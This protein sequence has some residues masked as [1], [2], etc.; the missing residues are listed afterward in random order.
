MMDGKMAVLEKIIAMAREKMGE[1]MKNRYSPKQ[2]MAGPSSV[3]LSVESED[4]L[5]ELG[6]EDLMKLMC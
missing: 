1:G 4:P 5:S 3:E 2:D 6:E